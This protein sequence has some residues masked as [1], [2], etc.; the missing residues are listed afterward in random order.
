MEN[1]GFYFKIDNKKAYDDRKTAT[2][3]IEMLANSLI[4]LTAN[5]TPASLKSLLAMLEGVSKGDIINEQ[6]IKN[7][8]TLAINRTTGIDV[9][10]DMQA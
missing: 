9:T 2:D 7:Y 3:A 4:V 1:K 10:G 5:H 6:A 8:Q